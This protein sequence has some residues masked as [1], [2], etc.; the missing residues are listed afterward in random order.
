M[1]SVKKTRNNLKTISPPESN[2][3]GSRHID[4]GTL[5]L[6]IGDE[7]CFKPTGEIFQV[8]SGNGTPGNGGTLIRLPRPEP[9]SGCSLFSIL[10]LSR[11][12]RGG[13]LP[14]DLD[15][16]ELWIYEGKTLREIYKKR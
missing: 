1:T 6:K 2:L 10:A 8:G 15:V 16:Y 3:P 11:L 4:F 14:F 7:I 13:N 5:G 9:R 12:L